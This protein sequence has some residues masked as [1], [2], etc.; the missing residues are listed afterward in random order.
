MRSVTLI[1]AMAVVSGLTCLLFG[2][3]CLGFVTELLSKPIRYG[4]MNG[5]AQ[6][7]LISQLPKRF[8]FSIDGGG[9]VQDRL[10]RGISLLR[11]ASQ[12]R[13][14]GGLPPS[15]GLVLPST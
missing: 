1:G 8:G 7:V 9:P 6:T 3:L 11:V 15:T 12:W 13:F 14:H 4:Y 10:A 2:L 5:I